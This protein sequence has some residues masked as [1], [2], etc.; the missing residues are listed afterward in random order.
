MDMKFRKMSHFI[1]TSRSKKMTKVR[2]RARL[3]FMIRVKQW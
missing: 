2:S 1:P 3:T